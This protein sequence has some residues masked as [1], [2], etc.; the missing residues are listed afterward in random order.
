M[1]E[2]PRPVSIYLYLCL[3]FT[4]FHFL[5]AKYLVD[6]RTK[7]KK[8]SCN[9]L[10]MTTKNKLCYLFLLLLPSF[11]SHSGVYIFKNFSSEHNKK[12]NKSA[13]REY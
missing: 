13:T 1:T 3:S 12:R 9:P 8:L 6:M 2:H 11:F 4:L 5:Q 10:V 7:I